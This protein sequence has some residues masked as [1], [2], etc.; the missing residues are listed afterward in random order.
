MKNKKT[1]YQLLFAFTFTVLFSNKSFGQETVTTCS[2]NQSFSH[3]HKYLY[4]DA[5]RDGMGGSSKTSSTYCTYIGAPV[6]YSFSSGD[7]DDSTPEIIGPK[8]WYLDN[9]KDG[10]GINNNTTNIGLCGD[11]NPSTTTVKY[12]LIAGDTNDNDPCITN[13]AKKTWYLD[14]DKDGF[15]TTVSTLLCAADPS[16]DTTKYVLNNTD[17]DDSNNK[18]NT[19]TVW[20][21]DNDGDGFGFGTPTTAANC[22]P[23]AANYANN[24]LDCNDA[25]K[26][27]DGMPLWYRDAD[28]DG[29]GNNS[30]TIKNCLQPVGYV[31]NNKDN[32]DAE[33]INRISYPNYNRTFPVGQSY[34]NTGNGSG[35]VT[36]SINNNILSI[37]ASVSYT[38]PFQYPS[39]PNI[40]IGVTPNLPNLDLGTLNVSGYAPNNYNTQYNVKITN[41][42]L[43]SVASNVPYTATSF[44]YGS[45]NIDLNGYATWYRD[46]DD[47]TFG[48]L[49]VTAISK[50]QPVG[51]VSNANDCDDTNASFNP[52]TKWYKDTNGDGALNELD[53]PPIVQCTKPLIG[54]YIIEKDPKFHWTHAVSYDLKGNITGA[55]RVYFNDLGKSNVSLSKNFVQNRVWGTETTY[56]TSGRVD[57]TSFIA[58][59][60]STAFDKTNFFYESAYAGFEPKKVITNPIYS[61]QD[62]KTTGAIEATCYIN[63]SVNFIAGS[64][65][66]LK[67]GFKMTATGSDSFKAYILP[68]SDMADS[69]TKL[70]NYYSD[71]N[72]IEPYQATAEQPYS[73][74]IY[75]PLNP[76]NVLQV[77]GG[78]KINGEWKTGRSYT[79]PAAQEMYYVYGKDY[80]DGATA[81]L[82]EEVITK[83]FKNVSVDA[84]G[85]ENV[86]FT[87]GEGKVLASARSGGALTYPVVSLIGT[88][89]FID[90]HIPAGIASSQISPIGGS[91]LYQVYDLKTGSVATT[92]TG[93]NA[94]R[95]QA[96]TP[97]STDSKTYITAGG[98]IVYDG[99]ALGIQYSVNYYDFAVNVY[100]KTGQLT[101]SI[102]PNGYTANTTVVAV[103]Q[104]MA[105][106]YTAFTSTFTYN[107]LGQLI[108]TTS[109]DEGTSRFAYR[110]DGQIRYSQSALQTDTKVSYTDYDT[111]GRPIE[112][113]VIT[114]TTGIWAQANANVD[115]T[116]LTGTRTEQTFT[117]YDEATDSA[118]GTLTLPNVLTTAGVAA[119]DYAQKNLSG[120]VAITYTK[121]DATGINA[122]T[123]YSYDIYGRVTWLVQYNQGLGAKTIHYLYDH[124]GNVKQVLFQKDKAA[125]RFVHQYTYDAN[126]VLQKVATS[127]DNINF[128]TQAEYSY[129]ATGELKRVN[130]AQGTQGLDYVYTLG[131]ALKSINHP[132]LEKGKDPGGDANDVFGLTLD[133]YA[134]DYLRTGRNIGTSPSIIPDYNGNIK[135]ARFAN[136]PIDFVSGT[137]AQQKA[138]SYTYDRNNWLSDA[139]FGTVNNDVIS[140][141]TGYQEGGLTYDANGNILTLQRTN[142][143]GA[144]QDNLTYGYKSNNQL[145][146]VA[147]AV[148]T[149]TL[150]GDIENQAAG[151]YVYDAIGQLTENVGEKTK[152]RYNTQGLVTEVQYNNQAVVRFFYNERG[153]RIKKESYSTASPYTLQSTDYYALDLSGNVMAIYNKLGT[154][155]IAQQE[156]PIFGTG[157]LGVYKRVDGS[158][159][160]Q[161]TDHLGNV[162]A[163]MKKT[164]TGVVS[165]LNFSDYYPYGEQ[166]AGR[167][168]QSDYRYAFQGQELDK[169]TGMEAFQLRLW[170]GRIG[171]WLS[172]DPKKDGYSMYWGMNNNPISNTDPDGGSVWGD[173]FNL[174]GVKIGS[175]GIKDNKAYLKYTTDNTLLTREQAISDIKGASESLFSITQKLNIGIDELNLR[176]VLS[177]LKQTEAGR[178]NKPLDYNSW[179]NNKNFTKY[180]YSENPEAYNKHPGTNPDSGGSAAG[181]YQFLKRFYIGIDFSPQS[182]DKAAI[183]NMTSSSY[184][185]AIS[186]NMYNFKITTQA[187]WTSLEHWNVPQLQK[188]FNSYRA[189][190]MQGHSN[191]GTP[192]GKLIKK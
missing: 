18:V 99:G 144:M 122:I 25:V 152:Y 4:L 114:G 102:Q 147:D 153:Q 191:I 121:P 169:E 133:Y 151:N 173:I 111:Y 22:Y 12:V 93:G 98:G 66:V 126:D 148:A 105:N 51:F 33:A 140:L 13:I 45:G 7:C 157:R 53:S 189:M 94:Y 78:N 38:S 76:A 48:D 35:S 85:V 129:Y 81:P 156:L 154:G 180:S 36:V 54:D 5:D 104:H 29:L 58:P 52:N 100:N 30:I 70:T 80:Y 123:W 143:T 163:V 161:I 106:T 138:Y 92:L 174:N 91:G 164:S 9:D 67:P 183:M 113:G 110:K 17:C 108:S 103:P 101:K 44:G 41:N 63:A 73:Q 97:P 171:R 24:N 71:A 159:S 168:T 1:I 68:A 176:S 6:G 82:G 57:K 112:S 125:E 137:T 21:L 86:S 179:N 139:K 77:T 19:I 109:P 55:S 14:G 11:T 186:G 107:G 60:A 124:R 190:E 50:T 184:K 188:T 16:T 141:S 128:T 75:D 115:N 120:N 149:P 46:F 59:V 64:S 65:I 26:N 3:W 8:I 39:M 74:N 20:Y 135:A 79:V 134:G 72:T 177:T 96:L 175:D 62:I 95:I 118:L 142:E 23:P 185:A 32:N 166:L 119:I 27:I 42:V 47:D 61:N 127:T 34:P 89:G 146:R 83:F 170:D 155:A 40:S 28:G 172:K 84:N 187:R 90:V 167:N 178:L 158:C 87:D 88:Q 165:V 136:K 56:D 181:A 132:S 31:A 69:T 116:L 182:Q 2:N 43:Y 145:D 117:I 160:Y 130:I 150:A 10:M 131:G 37:G 162:R 15:G 49:A 192:V